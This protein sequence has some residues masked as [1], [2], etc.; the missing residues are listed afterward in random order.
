[1]LASLQADKGT[2][3]GG[4]RAPSMSSFKTKLV[5]YFALI[6]AVPTALAFYGFDTLSKRHELQRVDTRLRADVRFALAG[7]SQQL[8][9]SERRALPVPL[10]VAVERIRRNLDPRDALLAVQGGEIVTG[11]YAGRGLALAPGVP[12]PIAL[13]GTQYRAILSSPLAAAGGVQFAALAPADDI[14][15]AVFAARGRIVLGLL[16]AVLGFGTLTYLLGLSVVRSL[17]RLVHGAEAIAR[18][19]LNARVRVRGRDEFSQVADAFNRMATQL[20]QRLD[21]LEEER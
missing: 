11:V 21:E 6:A 4:K 20:E 5:S 3:E 19:E 8:D 7:Y 17:M 13:G 15:D 16:G 1:M 9:A 18:G 14:N 12:A 10:N 2:G